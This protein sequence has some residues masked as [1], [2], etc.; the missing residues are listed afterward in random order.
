MNDF[1]KEEYAALS[2]IAKPVIPFSIIQKK[3]DEKAIE[4]GYENHNDFLTRTGWK[5]RFCNE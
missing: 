5:E 2:A 3:L 1:T 4:L